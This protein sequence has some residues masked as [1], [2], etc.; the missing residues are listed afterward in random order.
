VVARQQQ[1]L[2]VMQM[3]GNMS[4]HAF[5]CTNYTSG[6]AGLQLMNA[7]QGLSGTSRRKSAGFSNTGNPMIS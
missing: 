7:E 5:R 4:R 3:L 6:V 1:A 2:Q